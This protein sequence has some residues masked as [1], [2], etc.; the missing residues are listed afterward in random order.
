MKGC[1][2]VNLQQK[3]KVYGMLN[4]VT[5]KEMAEAIG[6]H[7]VH[8]RKVLNGQYSLSKAMK[9]KLETYLEQNK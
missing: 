4:K 9:T 5:Q 7:V 6:V 1:F 2:I 3:V 8:L